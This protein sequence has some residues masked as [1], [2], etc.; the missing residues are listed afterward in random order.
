MSIQSVYT[1]GKATEPATASA[2]AVKEFKG[3]YVVNGEVQRTWGEAIFRSDI[4]SLQKEYDESTKPTP[5]PEPT[6]YTWRTP[7]IWVGGIFNTIYTF[8]GDLFK[9]IF[10]PCFGKKEVSTEETKVETKRET[11]AVE[12]K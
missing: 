6:R 7:F 12:K 4:S 2:A 8:I 1:P 9:K 3:H 5:P 10:G 11:T